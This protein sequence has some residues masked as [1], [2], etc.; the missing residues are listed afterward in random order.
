MI[1]QGVGADDLAG[2]S[3]SSAGDINGDSIDD[4]IIGAPLADPDGKRDAGQAYVI[5][6][7]ITNQSPTINSQSFDVDENQTAVGSVAVSDP[8]LPL[9]DIFQTGNHTQS[10]RFSASGRPDENY[11]FLVFGR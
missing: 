6:G 2:G 5:F 8:D 7:A 9:R 11:K 1:F 10:R 4:L 3:V